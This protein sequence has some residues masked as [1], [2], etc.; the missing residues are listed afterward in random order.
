MS[1]IY[2]I[3]ELPGVTVT[4][5][6]PNRG[7][8]ALH[9]YIM[10]VNSMRNDIMK[11]RGISD[12]RWADLSKQAVNITGVESKNGTSVRYK[13]KNALPDWMLLSI[14]LEV[15]LCQYQGDYLR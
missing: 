8:K 4:A 3:V 7:N 12:S 9:D 15:R 10:G 14:Q 6:N 13:V 5:I 1:N 11:E 2:G